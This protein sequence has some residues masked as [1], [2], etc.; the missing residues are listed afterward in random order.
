MSGLGARLRTN[1]VALVLFSVAVLMASF[2][3]FATSGGFEE[4]YR[5][6]VML[7]EAGGVLPVRRSRPR[8]VTS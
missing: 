5:V 6:S 7:P 4:P 2:L 1:L 3:R 8:T